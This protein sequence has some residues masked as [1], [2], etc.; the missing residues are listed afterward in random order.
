MEGDKRKGRQMERK[1]KEL[2]I[3]SVMWAERLVV[4]RAVQRDG[5][6]KPVEE[7]MFLLDGLVASIRLFRP[8]VSVAPSRVKRRQ[9]AQKR[10]RDVG[11]KW[12]ESKMNSRARV[13]FVRDA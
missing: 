1:K 2:K 7:K 11:R 10:L 4:R 8:I 13:R 9:I 6:C 3:A 12:I 5:S